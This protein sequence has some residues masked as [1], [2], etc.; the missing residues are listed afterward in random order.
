MDYD[1]LVIGG[2]INGA[3]IAR[4]AQGRG[5]KT[6]LVERDDLASGTSSASTKLI[7]GGLRY[8]ETFEFRLVREALRERE[9]LM[10]SAPHII[11]PM[12]F[13]LPHS[14]EQRPRW[15]IRAGLF[16]YDNLARRELLP[17]SR[18]VRFDREFGAANPIL[19]AYKNG[20]TYS[21]CWVQD[22]RLV[23]LNAQDVVARGGTVLTRTAVTSARRSADQRHW[24]YTLR[25]TDGTLSHGT[26]RAVVN[27]AGPWADQV[28]SHVVA[29]NEPGQLRHVRGSHIVVPMIAGV[30]H[31]FLLQNDDGRVIFMI[32]YEQDFT[33][34]GTTD[35]NH[36]G[37]PG[38]AHCTDAEA[39]YL[40]QAVSR[41]L[42]TPVEMDQ[43]VWRYSGVRPLLFEEGKAAA[44][45]S[46]DYSFSLEGSAMQA[47]LLSVY[48]GKLT[49]C[50]ELAE[51]ALR[52][53]EGL[54]PMSPP[55]TA[56]AVLPGGEIGLDFDGALSGF[57]RAFPDLPQ[58][59]LHRWLRNYGSFAHA[60]AQNPGDDLGDGVFVGELRHL[61]DHE[62]ATRSNDVLWRRSKLGLRVSAQ[63]KTK[64]DA[65]FA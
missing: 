49:A 13:Y 3:A 38:Q 8:L 62:F 48:G 59:L 51:D 65:F 30:D 14:A 27:A 24:A 41:Y 58:D 19:D 25:S 47:P 60:I 6:L 52:Y 61:K 4:D 23:V 10:R 36:T 63:T 54:L 2:G 16:L 9:V 21:D 64:I 12:R 18:A 56:G 39:A 7:H 46:R 34:I 11:W 43:I 37:D 5:L 57:Q 32:P 28:D 33:L 22:A 1:L 29:K 15:M 40:C 53:F 20:F 50:R 42:R 26:A 35:V 44:Q 31:S 55:W 45:V 17:G